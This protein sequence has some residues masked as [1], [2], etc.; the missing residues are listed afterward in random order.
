MEAGG[1]SGWSGVEIVRG[2]SHTMRF[3]IIMRYFSI[4]FNV[5]KH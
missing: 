3:S 4:V 2:C 1:W 5:N